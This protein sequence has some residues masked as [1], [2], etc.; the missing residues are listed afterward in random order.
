MSFNGAKT[1]RPQDFNRGTL[2]KWAQKELTR[3]E[4]GVEYWKA[5]ATVGPEESNT[6]LDPYAEKPTPLGKDAHVAFVLGD[7]KSVQCYIQRDARTGRPYLYVYGSGI[8]LAVEP[9][10]AN[11]LRVVEVD[12]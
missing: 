3:L 1:G 10:S 4:A 2:P 11:T 12:R 5:K 6:F 8:Y 9:S 7:R